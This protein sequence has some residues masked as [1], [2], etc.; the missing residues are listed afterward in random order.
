[1]SSVNPVDFFMSADVTLSDKLLEI[2]YAVNGLVALYAAWKNLND[3]GNEHRF[4]SALFWGLL[5]FLFITGPWLP[6]EV[7]GVLVVVMV[8][9]AIL[10]RVSPGSDRDPSDAEMQ[11]GY[12]S[13]GM[14]IF[15]PALCIGV[16]ALAF[17]LFTPISSLVGIGVGVL[18][19]ALILMAYSRKNKPSVFLNDARRMLDA[20]GPLSLLPILLAGLGAVFTAAGVGEVIS[21]LVSSII[22]EGNM[23]VGIVVYAV[24][25]AVFTMVMGNAFAAITVMTVGVGA[26]FVLALG[27]D[28]VV[29]GSVA[30]TCGY[31]GTL[32]TP[33][34]ANFNMVPVA[35]LDMK[36]KNGVI[37]KQIPI[38]LVMLAVQIVYMI[39]MA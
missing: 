36:D 14:K 4:G 2:F 19:A 16:F 29:V 25:M 15:V 22:P 34:A 18:A 1:M 38:A 28:P 17:A 31:C 24:G 6:S 37:K 12:Q 30:L 8:V 26:P 27:A 39:V 5:G 33:M 23:V 21:G 20:V 3:T 11:S 32:C 9:P 13:I 7:V 35:I 10:K